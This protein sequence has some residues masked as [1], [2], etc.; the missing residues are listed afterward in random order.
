MKPQITFHEIEGIDLFTFDAN[1][2]TGG[3][4]TWGLPLDVIEMMVGKVL[5]VHDK[6]GEPSHSA[7]ICKKYPMEE[8]RVLL[9]PAH[10]QAGVV[11]QTW[12]FQSTLSSET[13]Y[14]GISSYSAAE[15]V[16]ISS[17]LV[18]NEATHEN[19]EREF[20]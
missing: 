7:F 20:A 8:H 3:E 19:I 17:G 18:W 4:L 5:H 2:D 13:P 9:V 12:L 16:R 1:R 11:C 6:T 10:E 14:V 15:L